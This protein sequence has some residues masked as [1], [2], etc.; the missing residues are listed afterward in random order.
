MFLY[1]F[2]VSNVY[3]GVVSA[4]TTVLTGALTTTGQVTILCHHESLR[5]ARAR[6]TCPRT[7]P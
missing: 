1:L 2:S 4:S 7:P 3:E 6:P 5:E